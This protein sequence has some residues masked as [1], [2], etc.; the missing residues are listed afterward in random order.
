MTIRT[1]AFGLVRALAST[2]GLSL[3]DRPP[4]DEAFY[5]AVCNLVARGGVSGRGSFPCLTNHDKCFGGRGCQVC[6]TGKLRS[7]VRFV[8]RL[9][10]QMLARNSIRRTV[11]TEQVGSLSVDRS[12]LGQRTQIPQVAWRASVVSG[13]GLRGY[14][15]ASVGTVNVAGGASL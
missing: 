9:L 1:P 4:S 3:T 15:A 5:T 2:R 12:D 10:E 11:P 14:K 8:G 7:P 13:R 6:L